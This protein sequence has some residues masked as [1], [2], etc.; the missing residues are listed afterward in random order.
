MPKHHVTQPKFPKNP[1][2]HHNHHARKKSSVVAK[3]YCRKAAGT[4]SVLSILGG[5]VR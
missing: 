4:K 5:P 3:I 1:C 2:K